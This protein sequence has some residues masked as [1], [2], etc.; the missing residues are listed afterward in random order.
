[1]RS[2][3]VGRLK[4]SRTRLCPPSARRVGRIQLDNSP[5]IPSPVSPGSCS[6]D[7]PRRVPRDL[8][9]DGGG[10]AALARLRWRDQPRPGGQWLGCRV[11]AARVLHTE[12]TSSQSVRCSCGRSSADPVQKAN[13]GRVHAGITHSH[14]SGG[15]YATTIPISI[16]LRFEVE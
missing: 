1:M 3:S 12:S 5:L 15:R 11:V 7:H 10:R 8:L 14:G 4:R 9:N 13:C 16:R 6:S 2:R